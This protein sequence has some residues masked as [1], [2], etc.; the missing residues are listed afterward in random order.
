M[1]GK[2]FN[3]NYVS[4]N[5]VS[6]GTIRFT[7]FVG[8]TD[9][10]AAQLETL[11]NNSDAAGLHTHT[12]LSAAPGGGMVSNVG[13]NFEFGISGLAW[14]S[15]QKT[16]GG[17]IYGIWAG[18]SLDHTSQLTNVG[19]N[20]H[21]TIDDKLTALYAYSGLVGH[22]YNSSQ[23]MSNWLASGEKLS[24]WFVGSSNI[25][26]H[27]T[28]SGFKWYQAYQ[29]G[30]KALPEAL[31]SNGLVKRTAAFSYTAVTDNSTQW[32]AI[33]G[34]GDKYSNWLA[35]GEQLSRW[36]VES[37]QAL[38][39][40]S[41]W[42]KAYLSGQNALPEVL[43]SNGIVK[44]VGAFNYTAVTDNSTAWDAIT[45]S[46][47]KYSLSCSRVID[48]FD[49]DSYVA[50]STALTKFLPSNQTRYGWGSAADAGTIAHGCSS[51]PSWVGLAPS[52]ASPI[53]FSF[54]VDTTNITVY[55]TSPDTEIFSWRAIV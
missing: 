39:S 23:Q 30:T 19:T 49:H 6:G 24:H 29:S 33:A 8:A 10:T 40:G 45:G 52:G 51:L 5:A 16:S 42:N 3:I 1:A 43:L 47:T 35:S 53:V 25:L 15:S 20:T 50:S 27:F 31:L 41:K 38:N 2:L 34:S 21:A 44:R 11:T 48:S 36:F 55:H 22:I 18:Q 13:A 37:S 26:S 9:A 17:T 46:G 4:G 28:V 14:I 7:S 12:G 32:D 54:K